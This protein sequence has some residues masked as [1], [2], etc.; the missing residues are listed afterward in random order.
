MTATITTFDAILK[1]F[2]L[3]PIQEQ[4]N[5]EIMVLQMFQKATVDWNGKVAVMPVHLGRNSG[6]DWA[7]EDASLPNAGNQTYDDLRINS[8]FLYGRFE[9]TGPAIA[10]AGKGGTNSF[11]GYVEAEMDRLVHD[12]KNVA[13]RDS[14]SGGTIKGFVPEYFEINTVAGGG[15]NTGAK[16]GIAYDGDFNIFAG[17]VTATATTWIRVNLLR[18]DTLD[19]VTLAAGTEIYVK[20]ANATAGTIDLYV[21]SGAP[22]APAVDGEIPATGDLSCP[23]VL[24]VSGVAGANEAG[25]A[26][27]GGTSGVA[28]AGIDVAL[29]AAKQCEGLFGNLGNPVHF[30]IDRSADNGTAVN[31]E[32]QSSLKRGLITQTAAAGAYV[33]PDITLTKIQGLMDEVILESGG[34]VNMLIMNPRQRQMYTKVLQGTSA[35]NLQVATEKASNGDGGF[36]G[37]SYGGVPIQVSRH[38]S[39]GMIVFLDTKTWKI[40]ELQGSE[41]ADLDGA[42]LSRVMNKDSWEGF[43]RWYMNIVCGQPNR[44]AIL[45]GVAL[46]P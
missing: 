2:Y 44:N 12:V 8:K 9:V 28:N 17:V 35:G 26:N 27:P 7:G 41:F 43:Y 30:S 40:L 10:S 37:L 23:L 15:F 36:L 1:E 29:A 13:D 31:T 25:G 18:G 4:L 5:N 39:N 22:A 11:V 42:V 14:V 21:N 20:G 19:S 38:V 3:G 32:L 6:V 16:S 45:C 46:T 24:Q 34:K 33:R